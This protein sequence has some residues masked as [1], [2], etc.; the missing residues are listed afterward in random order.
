MGALPEASLRTD[1]GVS[2]WRGTGGGHLGKRTASAEVKSR[3]KTGVLGGGEKADKEAEAGKAFLWGGWD[4]GHS[5]RGGRGAVAAEARGGCQIPQGTVPG[6]SKRGPTVPG[7]CIQMSHSAM[8]M[9]VR[10][11]ES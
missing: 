5:L 10:P 11:R 7:A 8:C 6:D 9:D 2:C 1:S 3:R 4:G